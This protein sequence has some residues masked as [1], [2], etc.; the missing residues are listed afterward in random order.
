[1]SV[2]PQ[3]H[4]LAVDAQALRQALDAHQRYLAGRAGGRRLNLTYAD[5]SSCSLEGLDLRDADMTGSLLADATLARCNLSRAILFG[6]DLREAD[7]RHVNL[8][9]ADLRGACLRG[10]NL[11]GADLAVQICARAGSRCRTSWMASASCGTST[12]PGS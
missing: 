8:K 10:A 1:M 11:A 7:M 5:L 3:Q 6:A 2:Q 9:K 12:G 4:H